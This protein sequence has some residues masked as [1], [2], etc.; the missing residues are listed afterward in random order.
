M[1]PTRLSAGVFFAKISEGFGGEGGDV[2]KGGFGGG[3][4]GSGV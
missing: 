2:V 3:R 1:F 4:E